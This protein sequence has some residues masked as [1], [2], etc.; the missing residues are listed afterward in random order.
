M[1]EV[2]W[3]SAAKVSCPNE[4]FDTLYD[5]WLNI[6]RKMYNDQ[7]RPAVRNL[8]SGS[9]FLPFLQLQGISGVEATYVRE[10][11]REEGGREGGEEEGRGGRGGEGREGRGGRTQPGGSRLSTTRTWLLVCRNTGHC[12]GGSMRGP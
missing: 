3:Q 10:G 5:E 6:S 11:G 2:L 9:D 8:A 7:Y 12:G 1:Y 4:G